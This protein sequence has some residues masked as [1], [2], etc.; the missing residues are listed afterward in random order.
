MPTVKEF[1]IRMEDR[2]GTL[3]KFCRTLADR[4]VNIMALHSFPT[5]GKA[6]VRIVVDN[7][8]T[9]KTVL[10]AERQTYTEAE[11]AQVKLPHKPGELARAAS[12]LGDANININYAYCGVEPST[13]APLLIFGVAE[14]DRA[15]TILE[16]AAAGATGT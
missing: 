14:V 4:G 5:E 10:D 12:R 11:V 15:V 6:L 9:A 1:A 3:G 13:N 2:P 7:S 16:Q 8:A